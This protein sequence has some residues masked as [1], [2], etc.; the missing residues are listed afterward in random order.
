[1]RINI[2][3]K[4][5]RKV[6]ESLKDHPAFEESKALFEDGKMP[7]E[8]LQ[9]MSL[10]PEILKAFGETGIG[11]Y[12]GGLLE[13]PLKEKVIL[14][15]SQDNQCQ[16]CTH[17]HRA[18]MHMPGIP[19]LQIDQLEAPGNLTKREEL[20]L[21]YTGAMMKDSNRV[22]D[23]LFAQ[24]KDNFSDDEI[25]ELTFLIGLINL[26]NMFNNALQ[27]T[28]HDDYTAKQQ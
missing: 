6:F 20:A 7:V 24:L 27:V 14:K 19:Q 13:R 17:S 4:R 28:Y 3:P 11:I 26:L 5:V 2:D 25:V 12:P 22:S 8:M 21:K 16:F 10:R 1:M 23:A 15:S 18:I 9:A